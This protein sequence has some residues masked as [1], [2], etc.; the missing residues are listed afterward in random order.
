MERDDALFQTARLITCGLY[1][2]IVLNDYIGTIM[3]LQHADKDCED[4]LQN[5]LE[6]SLCGAKFGEAR[7]NQISLQLNLTYR[8]HSAISV[9]DQHWLEQHIAKLLPDVRVEDMTAHN[10]LL[11]MRQFAAQQPSDPS[12]RTWAGLLRCPGKNFD[13]ADIAKILTDSTEDV[14]ASFGPRQIPIILKVFETMGIHQ[15]RA[16]GVASLNEVR[17]HFGLIAHKSFADINSD[18]EIARSLEMLYG[19]VENVELYPGVVVEEPSL[20][21]GSALETRRSISTT[22]AILFDAMA[23]I[24]SDRFCT[25]DDTA[26]HLTAFGHKEVSTDPSI[27]GGGVMY[28]LLMRALRKKAQQITRMKLTSLAG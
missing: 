3:S 7:G 12:E 1:M 10:M 14:A 27:A 5:D 9:K 22:R 28:K 20:S 18:P 24:Q 13:D 11:A 16:W 4:D 6:T 25:V 15:A 17:R 23:L 26:S 2:K 8:W 19:D 21:S